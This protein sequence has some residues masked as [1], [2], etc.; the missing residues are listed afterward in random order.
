[1]RKGDAIKFEKKDLF[2]PKQLGSY[3]ND[4][5]NFKTRFHQEIYHPKFTK[6]AASAGLDANDSQQSFHSEKSYN[7]ENK[8][9]ILSEN[10][11]I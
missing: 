2:I 9:F 8:K 4:Q 11:L 7:C 3:S 10:N 5:T 6:K 1:M